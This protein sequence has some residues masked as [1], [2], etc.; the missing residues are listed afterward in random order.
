MLDKRSFTAKLDTERGKFFKLGHKSI[1]LAGDVGGAIA[2]QGG[3]GGCVKAEPQ[4][5]T[6]ILQ[7]LS[8]QL[9]AEYAE[10]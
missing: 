8:Y 2:G 3:A 1:I 7:Q 5:Q 4:S 10:R 9:P 6:D